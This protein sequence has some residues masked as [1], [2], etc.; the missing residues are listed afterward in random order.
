MLRVYAEGGDIHTE[1]AMATM[2]ISPADWAL[3]EAGVKKDNRTKAKAVN[4]GFVYGM[5]W[6]GFKTYAKTQ[7]GVDYSD[8]RRRKPAPCTSRN[9]VG[10]CRGTNA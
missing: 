2:R 1:T 8:A 9:T 10:W 6:R 7:Y 5:G 3:L 4:F